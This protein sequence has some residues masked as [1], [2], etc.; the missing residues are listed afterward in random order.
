MKKFKTFEDAEGFLDSLASVEKHPDDPALR[1]V[2]RL[3]R[4]KEHLA[5]ACGDAGDPYALKVV[6]IAGT[7]GKGS[8][9]AMV[10]AM[11]TESNH[12]VGTFMSP[13][14][15]GVQER[16][17]LGGR[18]VAK[19]YMRDLVYE[20][21][22]AL[23]K[24]SKIEPTYFEMLTTCAVRAFLK[25]KVDVCVMEV[26]IG[27]RLDCTN[28]LPNVACAIT[29]ISRDHTKLLGNDTAS[30]AREK[31]GIIKGSPVVCARQK[32]EV[33]E[34]IREACEETGSS[35]LLIGEDVKLD[36]REVSGEG[37]KVSVTTWRRDF[38]D[39]TLPLR[40]ARQHENLGVALGLIETLGEREGLEVRQEEARRAL[41][42]VR[43]PAR[44]EFFPGKP[45]V[46]LDGAHNVASFENLVHHVK[47]DMDPKRVVSLFGI[48]GDKDV[49]DCL[50]M[51]CGISDYI[52]LTQFDSSR[53]V[54]V[55]EL[56]S[57]LP[58]D[59]SEES[60]S[61][62]KDPKAA[63]E[64]AL[65]EAGPDDLIIC[66]G[67]FYLAGTVRALILERECHGGESSS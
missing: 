27:G 18:Q 11:L 37:Q 29:N 9:A 36:R 66:A 50:R 28:V 25:E 15:V 43:V 46:I 30:I 32:P 54:A 67:S 58:G 20:T 53:S 8:V 23:E 33:L 2:F 17:L 42:S 1:R 55:D 57:H 7:K 6:H 47:H 63:Y 22:R 34:V 3:D 49:G 12:K 10:T 48:A 13:H 56:T 41:R 61:I 21:A 39:L 45:S 19:G 59:F 24:S 60:V 40:G 14:V 65:S 4:M 16:I 31:A 52:I 44:L 51:V 62:V 35:L 38:H 5:A 26:G 64:K